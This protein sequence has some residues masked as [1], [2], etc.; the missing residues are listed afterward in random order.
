LSEADRLVPIRECLR[1]CVGP[2]I[3]SEVKVE[4]EAEVEVQIEG[5]ES[6]AAPVIRTASQAGTG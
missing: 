2:G 6:D 5:A 3:R 4:V 1:G